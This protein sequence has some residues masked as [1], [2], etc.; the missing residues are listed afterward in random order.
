MV[1]TSDEVARL[2]MRD[3]RA[4]AGC[5]ALLTALEGGPLVVQV[6]SLV[7]VRAAS[8]SQ[9]ARALLMERQSHRQGWTPEEG[10]V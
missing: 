4:L 7:E 1:V 6:L 2:L 5:D 9:H 3:L 10:D 8:A